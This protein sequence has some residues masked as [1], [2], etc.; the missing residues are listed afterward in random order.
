[1]G[2]MADSTKITMTVT[3]AEK[4]QIEKQA[5]EAGMSPSNFIRFR[6]D[7]PPVKIGRPGRNGEST[8]K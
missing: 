5:R 3:T 1:M 6:V 2:T 8:A 7:L 4:Q